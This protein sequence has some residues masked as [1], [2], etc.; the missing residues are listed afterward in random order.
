MLRVSSVMI[1]RKDRLDD[2]PEAFQQYVTE[3]FIDQRVFGIDCLVAQCHC[4][5]PRHGQHFRPG[6]GLA[7]SH[8]VELMRFKDG[9]KEG[10]DLNGWM[11][12]HEQGQGDEQIFW[13]GCVTVTDVPVSYED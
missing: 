3:Y 11:W 2:A 10:Q 4:Y 1:V 12:D 7:P 5:H 6:T 8:S 13:R 9:L